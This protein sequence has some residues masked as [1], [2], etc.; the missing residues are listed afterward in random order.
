AQELLDAGCV[1]VQLY[2]AMIY[3]GPGLISKL[4]RDLGRHPAS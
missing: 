2:T 3:E 4:N 1:A